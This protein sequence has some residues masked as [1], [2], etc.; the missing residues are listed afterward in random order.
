M[1]QKKIE[2]EQ[3]KAKER[4]AK[5]DKNGAMMCL[6]RKKM[7]DNEITKMEGIQVTLETQVFLCSLCLLEVFL[8]AFA[9]RS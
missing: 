8:C 1:Y 2:N 7:Y 3:K 4:L 6:K 9:F 5:K